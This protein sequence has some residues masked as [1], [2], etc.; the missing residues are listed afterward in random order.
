MSTRVSSGQFQTVGAEVGVFVGAAVVG[1]DV[2]SIMG[3][4]VTVV[5]FEVEFVTVVEFE[6]EFVTMVE[7]EVEVRVVVVVEFAVGAGD[8]V[9]VGEEDNTVMFAVSVVFVR[10]ICL[11]RRY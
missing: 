5:E 2:G 6:V 3:T 9:G 4:G 8:T 10:V 11:T 1:A 7:F